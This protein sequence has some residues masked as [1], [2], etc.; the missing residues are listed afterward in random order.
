MRS[1]SGL[2]RPMTEGKNILSLLAQTTRPRKSTGKGGNRARF[3]T[4]IILRWVEMLSAQ[5]CV[6][7]PR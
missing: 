1:S 4:I 7:I 6:R 5:S 2:Q 3:K